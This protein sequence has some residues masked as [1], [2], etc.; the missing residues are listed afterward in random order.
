MK[1]KSIGGVGSVSLVDYIII[2]LWNYQ[3]TLAAGSYVVIIIDP[4]ESSKNK[5][6][7]NDYPRSDLN[8]ERGIDQQ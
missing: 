8:F 7:D 1:Q 6:I 2:N 3:I 4:L 5:T